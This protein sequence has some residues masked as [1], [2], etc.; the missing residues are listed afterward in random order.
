MGKKR[1]TVLKWLHTNSLIN[2]KVSF[3]T[4]TEKLSKFTWTFRKANNIKVH[5]R[6]RFIKKEVQFANNTGQNIWNKVKKSSKIWQEQK[7]LITASVQILITIAIV[8][9]LEWKLGTRLYLRPILTFSLYFFIWSLKSS[10]V[11][12][13]VR[14]L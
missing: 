11:R 14:Q 9:F 13:L 10:V 8:L 7:T 3:W 12:Q 2:L 4:L 5:F 1:D 6:Q